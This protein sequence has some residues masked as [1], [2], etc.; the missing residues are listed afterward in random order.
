MPHSGTTSAGSPYKTSRKVPRP[1]KDS[2]SSLASEDS[3]QSEPR[4]QGSKYPSATRR[5]TSSK[6]SAGDTSPEDGDD[7]EGEDE[8]EESDEEPD[9]VAP[10]GGPSSK[11]G[12]QTGLSLSLTNTSLGKRGR[13]PAS[14]GNDERPMSKMSRT[15]EATAE[16]SDDDAA[17]AALDDDDFSDGDEG[18]EDDEGEFEQDEEDEIIRGAEDEQAQWADRHGSF[19]SVDSFFGMLGGVDP[20][21]YPQRPTT[22]FGEE[23]ARVEQSQR[24]SSMAASTAGETADTDVP[25]RRVR[26][27]DE[28]TRSSSSTESED[29]APVYPDLFLPQDQLDPGFR[30]FLE[31]SNDQQNSDSEDSFSEFANDDRLIEELDD[32]ADSE[33]GSSGYESTLLETFASK[34]TANMTPS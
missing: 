33:S 2:D 22:F 26:F 4:N 9:T 10:F 18:D 1:R 12:H 19:S 21:L 31:F 29:E 13:S 32:D 7:E 6:K 28:V 17:Y 27:A 5:P 30:R 11:R 3:F 14:D 20:G 16:T 34:L 24:R 15:S 25:V 23:L 8:D